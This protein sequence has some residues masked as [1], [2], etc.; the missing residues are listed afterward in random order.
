MKIAIEG[1]NELSDSDLE[2]IA[3]VWSTIKTRAVCLIKIS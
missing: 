1:P 2:Q 3:D